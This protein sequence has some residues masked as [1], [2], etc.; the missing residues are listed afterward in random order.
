MARFGFDVNTYEA[1]TGPGNYEPIPEGEYQLM[2]EEAEEKQTSTGSGSYIKA[3]FQVLGPTHTGRLLWMNFNIHNKSQKAEEIGRKQI[4][5]WARACG[6]PNAADTD[7]LINRPF[8]ASV[9]IEE[10]KTGKYAPQNR[11]SGFK[12]ETAPAPKVSS[13]PRA[14]SAAAPSPAAPSGPA[15]V[16][17]SA[18]P[19]PSKAGGKKAPWDE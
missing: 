9:T 4:A 14:A 12:V 1:D 8:H 7:E 13:A 18:A 10:D 15:A 2:C 19:S 3:R 6:L 17:S 16:A 11:I 5:G